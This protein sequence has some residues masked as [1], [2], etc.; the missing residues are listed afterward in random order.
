M[1]N[2]RELMQ[3]VQEQCWVDALFKGLSKPVKDFVFS[4]GI[5]SSWH[6]LLQLV[7]KFENSPYHVT[8]NKILEMQCEVEIGKLRNPCV[9]HPN[10]DED[11]DKPIESGYETDSS[12][13]SK[14]CQHKHR[15]KIKATRKMIS[16]FGPIFHTKEHQKDRDAQPKSC[17]KRAY[18]YN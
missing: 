12:V 8:A 16:S 5:P 17:R 7:R 18:K 10:D 11:E 2:A 9:S 6:E 4:R 14:N 15:K 13:G 3:K 1:Y